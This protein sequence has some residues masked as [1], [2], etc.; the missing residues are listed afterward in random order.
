MFVMENKVIII[1]KLTEVNFYD[2]TFQRI[3]I[4]RSTDVIGAFQKVSEVLLEDQN[5][6]VKAIKKYNKVQEQTKRLS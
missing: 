6:G 5:F 1:W 4:A 2:K 3:N